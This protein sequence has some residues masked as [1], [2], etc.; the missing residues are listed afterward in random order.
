LPLSRTAGHAPRGGLPPTLWGGVE[1]SQR[2]DAHQDILQ[3]HS[4]HALL[5]L[6]QQVTQNRRVFFSMLKAIRQVSDVP[7][8]MLTAR[9]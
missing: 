6:V 1:L 8:I 7:V 3:V 4:P 5:D 2:A 9:G